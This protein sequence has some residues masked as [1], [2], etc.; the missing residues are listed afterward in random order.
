MLQTVKRRLQLLGPLS[1]TDYFLTAVLLAIFKTFT[2]ALGFVIFT[3][4]FPP[5]WQLWLP[6]YSTF[7]TLFSG[8]PDWFPPAYFVWSIPFAFLALSLSV[9]RAIDAGL[10]PWWGLWA[11]VPYANVLMFAALAFW[12]REVSSI[13]G[14][15]LNDENNPEQRLNAETERWEK[16]HGS[17]AGTDIIALLMGPAMALF[18]MAFY[19]YGLGEY[20]IALFFLAPIH[21]AAWTAFLVNCRV[22]RGF[23]P[24]LGWAMLS[25]ALGAFCLLAFA[26]EGAI[27]IAMAAPIVAILTLLGALLG[28][29]ISLAERQAFR[30]DRFYSLAPI[31]L[32]LPVGGMIDACMFSPPL[33]AV[34][35]VTIV[36]APPEIVWQN[37]V[38]FPDLPAERE[39]FFDLGISCPV[40]AT[41]EGQG[42]GAVRH[43]R[44]TTGTFVEPITAWNAPHRLAF[45]VRE[46]PDPMREL[47]PWGHVHTPHMTQGL[48]CERGEFRLE[49]LP[50]G[51]TQLSGTTW[52]RLGLA[53]HGY[54]TMWSDVIIHR[55]H[56]RVLN[57]VR[58]LSESSE[59]KPRTK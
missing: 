49:P 48:V 35:T 50:D 33:R 16:A 6:K 9:R 7:E 32:V 42:V 37:V 30:N 38:S 58:T 41:I 20:G 39:W 2:E 15:S 5:V 28:W 52:Y 45:D 21:A 40:G 1:Q 47:T 11:I 22:Y 23:L 51:R 55:I 4:R 57:H 8:A 17:T 3:D 43:C 24:S 29:T 14:S 19:V 46:Q 26:L 54:W 10:S 18:S 31:A 44:F 56:H 13:E 27:C 25:A 53:P 34:R 12:P 59:N 36:D